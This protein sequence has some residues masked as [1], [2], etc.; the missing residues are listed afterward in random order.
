MVKDFNIGGKINA[1]FYAGILTSSLALAEALTG[2]SWGS[3]S[4]SVGRKLVLFTGR[5]GALMFLL[6]MGF[7]T[8]L[9]NRCG[10][11]T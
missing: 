9:G 2:I 8:T 4:D 10:T 3:L 11:P 7:A 6:V 5:G 1:L